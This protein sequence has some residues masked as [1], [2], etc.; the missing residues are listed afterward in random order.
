MNKNIKHINFKHIA[1]VLYLFTCSCSSSYLPLNQNVMKFEKKGDIVVSS[2][3]SPLYF[4]LGMSGGYAISDNFGVYSS[5]NNF[6]ITQ[7]RN[8]YHFI[9][10][11][12]WD[13]E[14]IIYK[15][16]KSGLYTGLNV[17]VGF[18]GLDIHDSKRNLINRQ[19]LLPTLGVHYLN[20]S[21]HAALSCRFA[22][23]GSNTFYIDKPYL[24]KYNGVPFYEKNV[25]Y[26]IEP[27][28]SSGFTLD[29]VKIEM[30]YSV[31]VKNPKSSINYKSINI[32]W[33]A[34]V[35]LRKLFKDKNAPVSKLRWTL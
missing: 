28:I 26:F 12:M 25:D 6:E 8:G 27:A 1:F 13:N 16:Y 10:D 14:L 4:D 20:N 21:R 9:D 32:G 34:S 24:S 33:T 17:G 7:D 29:I 5:F 22:R 11:F 19:C 18:G 31:I 15:K 30:Q 23:F 3:I 35:N 2:Y